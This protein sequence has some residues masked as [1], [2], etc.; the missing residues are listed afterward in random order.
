M[1]AIRPELLKKQVNHLFGFFEDPQ[2]FVSTLKELFDYYADRTRRPGQ[3]SQKPSLI[4]SYVI[5]RQVSRQIERYFQENVKRQPESGCQIA[6][7]L[8]EENWFEYRVLAFMILGWLPS[9]HKDQVA[10]RLEGW[11]NECGQDRVLDTSFTKGTTLIWKTSPDLLIKLLETWLTSPEMRTRKW[12][13]RVINGLVKEPTFPNL[14]AVFGYLSPFVQ[15]VSSAPDADL[16]VI[17]QHLADRES[18]E[19]SYFLQRNYV[20]SENPGIHTLMRQSLEYFEPHTR[21]EV[22]NYLQQA[23]E[24]TGEG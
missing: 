20:V 11:C 10:L 5:P 8:W 7:L 24:E 19:T 2:K 1:P 23:R 9:E 16:V 14:P 4:R 13:L 17:V 3:R 12:G 15:S 6:D 22:R 18:K 21:Q